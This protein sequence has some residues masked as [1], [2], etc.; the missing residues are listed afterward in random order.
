MSTSTN[1]AGKLV[2]AAQIESDCPERL[3]ALGNRIK[4]HLEKA[5]QAERRADNHHTSAG[6]L[7]AQVKEACTEGGFD[8]FRARYCPDLGKTRVYELLAIASGTK[9]AEGIRAENAERNRRHR[10]KQKA[11]ELV[12]HVT[13]EEP[14]SAAPSPTLAWTPEPTP[15]PRGRRTPAEVRRDQYQHGFWVLCNMVEE[16]CSLAI[17]PNLDPEAA[18]ADS[19]MLAKAIRRLRIRKAALD[20]VAQ[21]GDAKVAA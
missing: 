10:A 4:A 20:T 16:A 1:D 19:A 5:G 9:S 14:E 7:L 3:E 6:I 12:R 11:A 2:T 13:D 21:S 17:P 8:A 15:A 18:A